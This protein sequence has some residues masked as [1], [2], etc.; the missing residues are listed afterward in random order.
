MLQKIRF[1]GKTKGGEAVLYLQDE[2]LI[3]ENKTV[4]PTCISY[5]FTQ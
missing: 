2:Y 4:H 1:L 5:R 3:R